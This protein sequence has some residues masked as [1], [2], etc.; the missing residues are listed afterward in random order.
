[1]DTL[2][3]Y[4]H[5]T[6]STCPARSSSR[7]EPLPVMNRR[8]ALVV[9]VIGLVGGTQSAIASSPEHCVSILEP[10]SESSGEKI[11]DAVLV[12]LGCFDTYAEAVEV[13]TS[14]GTGL[15]RGSVPSSLT[16]AVL[17]ESTEPGASSVLI[18]T[19]YVLQ[20]FNG[21]SRSYFA[22]STC[23]SDVSWSVAYVGDSWNDDFE[24]GKGFGGC[25]SNRKF[26]HSDF[27]G[28]VRTCNPSCGG[29]GAL[30]NEVSSLRWRP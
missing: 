18:G 11:I 28:D 27:G 14:G 21:N 19:E 6:E 26:A 4:V 25:D 15:P 9:A 16:E 8:A 1:M 17:A 20:S 5:V 22:P 3:L 10:T 30:N 7:R 24:S 12:D 29:Y 23:S 2:R 13:G